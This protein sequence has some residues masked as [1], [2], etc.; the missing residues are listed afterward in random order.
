MATNFSTVPIQYAQ[1]MGPIIAQIDA[2]TASAFGN[3]T[4]N[5]PQVTTMSSNAYTFLGGA[6]NAI[7]STVSNFGLTTNNA[8]VNATAASNATVNTLGNQAVQNYQLLAQQSG[9]K[10]K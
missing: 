10:K 4:A 8:V 1:A 9:K 7:T 2:Q 5:L 6:N 3:L